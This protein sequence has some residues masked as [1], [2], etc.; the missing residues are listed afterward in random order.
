MNFDAM[1]SPDNSAAVLNTAHVF[2]TIGAHRLRELVHNSTGAKEC[3]PDV[4]PINVE[5]NVIKK[6]LNKIR[7]CLFNCFQRA[8]EANK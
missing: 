4:E 8:K 6:P 2:K 1:I 7:F 3:V 5:R